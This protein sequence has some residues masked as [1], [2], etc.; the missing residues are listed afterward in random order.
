MTRPPS[1]SESTFTPP[2]PHLVALGL[3]SV[4]VVLLSL[5]MWTGRFLAGPHSDQFVAGFAIRLWGALQWRATGSIPLWN[6]E[7]MG[8]VPV[9]A[10]FGDL[11]YPT[12]LL[13]LVL[14]TIT[15]MNVSFVAHYILAGFFTYLLL[16]LLGFSWLGAVVG[17]T[18]Y[19]MS[20][21]VS[22]LVSPGHDG[23]LFVSAL[24]PLM[25]IG[26]VLVFR[27]KRLEGHALLALAVGLAVLSPQYQMAYYAL[28]ATGLFALYLAFGE[29][30]DRP[31]AD[32]AGALA[33]AFAAVLVGFG[34]SMIQVLPFLQ[35]LPFSPRAEA[36]GFAWSVSYDLPWAHVPEFVIAGF[37]GAKETYWGPNPL[38]LHSEYLGLSVVG[39][40]ALGVT[41]ERRR[42]LYWL[43]GIG[44]LFLL[45]SL[46]DGTPFYRLWWAVMPY[47][48]QTRAPGM[49]FYV[50]A[51]VLAVM[52]GLGA[53][54]V[55]RG[56][57]KV[58]ALVALAVAAVLALLAAAG[59]IG[60]VAGGIARAVSRDRMGAL[61]AGVRDAIA[62]G[63]FGSAAMLGLGAAL[64]LARLRSRLK[65]AVFVVALPLVL[66]ADLTLDARHFWQWSEPTEVYVDD[67]IVD[68]LRDETRP[69]RVLD[70][71]V[72][73]GT[74]LMA[75]NV[76]QVLGY[77]GNEI[78]F[79]DALLGGKN[80]WR[81]LLSSDRLWGLLAVRFMILPDSTSLPGYVMEMGPVTT[82]E[83]RIAYVY[84]AEQPPPYAWVVGG[85][86]RA[87]DDQAIGAIMNRSV[88]LGRVVF[89]E[90]VAPLPP[91]LG[92]V[93]DSVPVRAR[94]TA[95]QPG[96]MTIDLE[97]AM[98][99]D[100]YLVV[101]ENWYPD[102]KATV[103]GADADVWRGNASLLTVPVSGGA[104]RIELVIESGRYRLGRSITVISLVLVAVGL[105]APTVVRRRRSRV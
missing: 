103:D 7:M 41:T 15:A 101:S 94:V 39:L 84:R 53:E 20:G 59:V 90:E 6:P 87:A 26:L 17:G 82:G 97:P 56:V 33:L 75:H 9:F 42:L 49:A 96:H 31:L 77:H 89:L 60:D 79:Y 29:S 62:I 40:A 37:T 88:P 22:S 58:G 69:Y 51:F 70:L 95:W 52:A 1:T 63:A 61:P 98:P 25:M 81:N 12:S 72:Y 48:K 8:G 102:W 47:V 43:G 100:G 78:R 11:F 65:P 13:R 45:V 14:P 18:A 99:R 2:R 105:V 68:R 57:G 19:E 32:R 85:A 34:I 4:W 80:V 50:V 44:A 23:K 35:Y 21:V 83:G 16:R 27:R 54:R 10:G 55:E 30:S 104:S 46:G 66:G 76:S 36:G 38:K 67:A 73:S 64:I 3:L 74:A 86:V 24:L 5:P 91:P 71:G 93:P 28:I 92:A